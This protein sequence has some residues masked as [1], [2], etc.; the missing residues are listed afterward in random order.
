MFSSLILFDI[1]LQI[2]T[3]DGENF[4]LYRACLGFSYQFDWKVILFFNLVQFIQSGPT[5]SFQLCPFKLSQ[6]ANP[7]K[8]MPITE[9]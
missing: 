9:V 6:L 5:Q 4:K 8:K 2:F 3:R 7:E 1:D